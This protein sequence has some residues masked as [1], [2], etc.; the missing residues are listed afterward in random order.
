MVHFILLVALRAM[1]SLRFLW[2]G[3]GIQR[4]ATARIDP[5]QREGNFCRTSGFS[6]NVPAMNA[7]DIVGV[8]LA[9]GL[10]TRMGG[11]DK[12]LLSLA[13]R[14]VLA[15]VIERLRPQVGRLVINANGDPARFAAF[16]LPVVADTVPGHPGPLG[17]IL[18]GLLHARAIGADAIVTAAGD[19][20]FLPRDLVSRLAAAAGSGAAAA[21]SR[22]RLHPVEGCFPVTLA[23][24]LEAFIHASPKRRVVD[25]VSS[26]GAV[27]VDFPDGPGGYDPFFN[28][29]TAGDLRR[30]EA[31]AATAT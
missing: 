22:G 20:P 1:A 8:I 18:A 19:T 29:N 10:S 30:A 2:N 21:R 9:G 6:T 3:E 11:G 16:G 28:L 15:H 31:I 26:I 4:P 17:G 7:T 5:E 12:P 14:T 23:E 25:W 24:G 27:P 13:G